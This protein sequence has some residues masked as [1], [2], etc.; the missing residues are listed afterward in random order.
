LQLAV[1]Q[2]ADVESLE[3]LMDLSDRWEAK[4]AQKAYYDAMAAFQRGCPIIERADKAHTSK[5]A[6][7]ERIVMTVRD[8]LAD[9]GLSYRFENAETDGKFSVTCVITHLDG[10]SERTTMTASADT[11]GSKNP[12]QAIGSTTT[13]LQRYTL[14]GALGIVTGGEDVD[15]GKPAELVSDKQIILM[16]ELIDESDMTEKEFLHLAKIKALA[17]LPENLFDRACKRIKDGEKK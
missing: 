14:C 6:T 8:N 2:G 1:T 17:D 15:G 4:Q 11:S 10:H 9:A 16:R 3:K 12:I 7:L 13:Y 5:Y